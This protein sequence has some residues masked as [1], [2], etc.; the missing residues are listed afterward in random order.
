MN[1]I[2]NIILPI[3]ELPILGGV[4]GGTVTILQLMS[5]SNIYSSLSNADE[6]DAP[7]PY[8]KFYNSQK[9]VADAASTANGTIMVDSNSTKQEEA[10]SMLTIPSR[11]G[12]IQ[13]YLPATIIAGLC[14]FVLPKLD[15]EIFDFDSSPSLEDMSRLVVIAGT[16][17]QL[18]LASI[19][20]FIHFVKRLF[21]IKYLHSFEGS[22][23]M[24]IAVSHL[25]SIYFLIHSTIVCLLSV[26]NPSMAS[27][28]IGTCLF[29]IGEIGNFYHHY[30]LAKLRTTS[31]SSSSM[32][33]SSS[34]SSVSS[35]T[36]KERQKADSNSYVLPTGGFF[37]YVLSAH[38][39]FEIITWIGMAIIAQHVNVW[40]TVIIIVGYL[41]QRA[42]HQ[43]EWYEQKGMISQEQKK[44]YVI[45]PFVYCKKK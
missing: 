24:P 44:K 43:Y 20:C 33:R 11:N 16:T 30:L 6:K 34:E 10:S 15:T 40:F 36:G 5:I 37:D 38:Y 17:F 25:M 3:I 18:K 13:M 4:V 39:F 45:I 14:C 19:L 42:K 9:H 29:V 2:C 35:M 32:L 7:T 26:T 41:S 1:N 23:V 31:E 22:K 21:E 12:M 28:I 8:G 27:M